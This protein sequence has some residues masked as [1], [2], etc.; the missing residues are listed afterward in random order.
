MCYISQFEVKKEKK[1]AALQY[2]DNRN[3]N[4]RFSDKEY[5]NWGK[6]RS[7]F[8]FFLL[9]CDSLFTSSLWWDDFAIC[10][11]ATVNQWKI[12]QRVHVFAMTTDTDCIIYFQAYQELQLCF[13]KKRKKN[14]YWETI[15]LKKEKK[16]RQNTKTTIHI[17]WGILNSEPLIM[18]IYNSL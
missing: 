14:K 4:N 12:S 10:L 8:V 9:K 2:L 17:S 7:S 1:K 18:R 16:E 3:L 15:L 5:D 6:L 13:K 11:L